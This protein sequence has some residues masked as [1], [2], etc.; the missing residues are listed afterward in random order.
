[1]HTN[2]HKATAADNLFAALTKDF[3]SPWRF[4]HYPPDKRGRVFLKTIFSRNGHS[5][6][7]L[8]THGGDGDNFNLGDDAA[9]ALVLFVNAMHAEK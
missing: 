1:M 6:L 4:A 7:H 8:E 5:V 9:I 3:P 2:D